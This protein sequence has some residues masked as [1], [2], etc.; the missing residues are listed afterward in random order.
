MAREYLGPMDAD[1]NSLVRLAIEDYCFDNPE[2]ARR[3]TN[4]I[5]KRK[6]DLFHVYTKDELYDHIRTMDAIRA[7][8]VGTLMGRPLEDDGLYVDDL[9]HGGFSIIPNP[10]QYMVDVISGNWKDIVRGQYIVPAELRHIIDRVMAQPNA[11]A[12][13][14]IRRAGSPK[15]KTPAKKAAARKATTG[16]R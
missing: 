15:A 13:K 9:K 7:F 3:L 14:C 11:T 2:E 8:Q 12:S 10:G 5:Y 1:G 16:R 6:G 4:Q